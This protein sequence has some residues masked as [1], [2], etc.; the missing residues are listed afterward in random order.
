MVEASLA[1][2]WA[3]A[4]AFAIL[5]YVVL[6]GFDLGVGMLFGTTRDEGYRRTMM[7]AIA[8]VW[9]GNETWLL[10]VGAGLY[11]AFPDVYAIFLSALYLPVGLLMV[12]LILRGVAFEFRHRGGRLR[13]VWDAGFVA[14]SLVAAFVQG[15]AIGAMVQE[16]PIAGGQF[17]GQP[18]HWLTPFTVLCGA[19]LAIGYA[20][21]GATWLVVKTT[22]GL[23]DWA[24]ARI[25][26]LTGGVILV[27]ALT[28][29]LAL[30]DDLR[31]MGRWMEAPWLLV[32]PIIGAGAVLGAI[33]GWRTRRDW[34]PFAMVVVIF[35]AAFATMAGSFWP[36]MVPFSLTIEEA[37]APHASLSFLFYGAGLVA[38]PIIVVYTAVVY[39]IFRGKVDLE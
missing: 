25:P 3:V 19:G 2:F 33:Q 15:A 1:T 30:T 4:L 14:G 21:L 13:P 39:W 12:A 32:F 35:S 8:P 18:L 38:L 27:L 11:G 28:F 17:T 31:V 10:I 20:L 29:T 5:V 34:L 37:A 6:D 7:G 16:L 9:D 23:R 24:Y 22:G 26:W 36:Y